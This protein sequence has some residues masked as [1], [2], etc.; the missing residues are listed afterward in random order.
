MCPEAAAI[1]LDCLNSGAI[2]DIDPFAASR[3]QESVEP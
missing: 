1:L 3:A 2:P